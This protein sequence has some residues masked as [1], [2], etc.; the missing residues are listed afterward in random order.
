MVS[1]MKMDTARF[2]IIDIY[3]QQMIHFQKGLPGFEELN[4]FVLIGL[5]QT[6]PFLW[7]QSLDADIALPV[8]SPFDIMDGYAPVIEDSQ[9]QALDLERDE[10]LLVLV[11]SVIPPEVQLMTANLAA[12]VLINLANNQGVQALLEDDRYPTRHPIYGAI[13][14][15]LQEDTNHVGHHETSRRINPA[16]R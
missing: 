9:I 8:V 16:G 5:D 14:E 6:R 11:V 15:K 1:D 10:D 13:C 2:G 12:P 7:L 3:E 4:R